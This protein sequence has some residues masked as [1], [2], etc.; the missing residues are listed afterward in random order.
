[1]N[2]TVLGKA[3]RTLIEETNPMGG[4]GLLHQDKLVCDDNKPTKL[5]NYT[6]AVLE[7]GASVG[8]HG[9]E[10]ESEYYFI[11]SGT[12]EYDDNGTKIPV[13]AGDVTFTPSGC[14]HGIANTGDVPM[15]FMTLIIL[16]QIRSCDFIIT[17]FFRAKLCYKK[18][19]QWVY[20]LKRL[21]YNKGKSNTGGKDYV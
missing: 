21:F 4:T 10:G 14:G 5:R 12:G 8:Y 13:K 18:S 7:P 9:H 3:N 11:L 6:K 17:A 1:M 19:K 15:E 16:D 2:Y 20:K